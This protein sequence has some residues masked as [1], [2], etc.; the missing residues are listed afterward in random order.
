M[1][2]RVINYILLQNTQLENLRNNN[3][4]SVMKLFQQFL[5]RALIKTYM[6]QTLKCIY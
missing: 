6:M 3:C 4:S 5:I 1:K 2:K